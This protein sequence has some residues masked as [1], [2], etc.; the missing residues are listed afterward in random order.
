MLQELLQLVRLLVLLALALLRCL[1]VV[2]LCRIQ[3]SD[4][5]R[6]RLVLALNVFGDL[7][8]RLHEADLDGGV[9]L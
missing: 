1:A 5:P 2:A 7:P 9:A 3:G 6:K 8:G 4:A